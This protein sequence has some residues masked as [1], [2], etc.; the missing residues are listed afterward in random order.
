MPSKRKSNH[1]NS[2]SKA[3][4]KVTKKTNK[5]SRDN[6]NR[7]RNDNYKKNNKVKHQAKKI[8]EELTHGNDLYNIS[9]TPKNQQKTKETTVRKSVLD[10]IQKSI[11]DINSAIDAFEKL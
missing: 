10:R 11:V 2:P 8:M 7:S 9:Q 5:I 3:A 6:P 4:F 1:K